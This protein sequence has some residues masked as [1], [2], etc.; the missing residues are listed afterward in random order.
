MIARRCICK[1]GDVCTIC[2]PR[3]DLSFGELKTKRKH[4]KTRTISSLNSDSD[5]SVKNRDPRVLLDM[6][7]HL[8]PKPPSFVT[9]SVSGTN[10]SFMGAGSISQR[11][12][13]VIE[14][15]KFLSNS[16]FHSTS[17]AKNRG[18]CS[19]SKNF[20][21]IANSV[22]TELNEEYLKSN[23][24]Y[25]KDE[26]FFQK[27]IIQSVSTASISNQL[28][29]HSSSDSE[30]NEKSSRVLRKSKKSSPGSKSKFKT[31]L[32]IKSPLETPKI[33]MV[34]ENS[35]AESLSSYQT[36]VTSVSV[37][38]LPASLTSHSSGE[39]HHHSEA[40]S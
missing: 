1:T 15:N 24:A 9:A 20:S 3:L 16:N 37:D 27:P 19:V 2:V 5:C 25:L 21:E 12:R 34:I 4:N 36:S 30:K 10:A 8:E 7:L 40:S 14:N 11:K 22:M 13:E 39:L 23:I 29:F 17:N 6:P 35:E 33:D 28:G 26:P 18:H 31:S 38:N 32:V